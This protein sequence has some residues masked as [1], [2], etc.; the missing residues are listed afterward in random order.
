MGDLTGDE[1][2]APVPHRLFQG[3]IDADPRTDSAPKL[4]KQ[5]SIGAPDIEN[6]R[7]SRDVASHFGNPL[8]L[9]E[10]VYPLEMMTWHDAC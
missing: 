6:T 1:L 4:P 7:T 10:S 5:G 3:W 9:D 8:A 2:E